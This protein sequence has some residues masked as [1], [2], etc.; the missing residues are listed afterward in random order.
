MP[1]RSFKKVPLIFLFGYVLKM[2]PKFPR[3]F[4]KTQYHR[5]LL[6]ISVHF[7]HCLAQIVHSLNS[8]C[9]FDV[10]ISLI[11]CYFGLVPSIV[12]S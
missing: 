11:T 2:P 7:I 4:R 1:E 8:F 5:L 3:Y 9:Y 6:M 12:V 10:L